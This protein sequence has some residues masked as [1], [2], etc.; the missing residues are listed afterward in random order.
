MNNLQPNPDRSEQDNFRKQKESDNNKNQQDQQQSA[1]ES[2]DNDGLTSSEL[3]DSTNE[4]K[5]SMGSGQRQ[6]SN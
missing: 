5:G 6:D 3:P 4:N 1:N 2:P